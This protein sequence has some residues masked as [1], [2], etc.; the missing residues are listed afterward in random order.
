MS[1]WARLS[2]GMWIEGA[3]KERL[4][5]ETFLVVDSHGRESMISKKDICHKEPACDIDADDLSKLTTP[6]DS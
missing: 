2:C 5:G 1:I 6:D 4:D 3:V